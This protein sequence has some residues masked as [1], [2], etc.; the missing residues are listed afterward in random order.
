MSK[1][2][3][4]ISGEHSVA[5][6]KFRIAMNGGKFTKAQ[7]I[8]I[9][10]EDG[11]PTNKC[12]WSTFLKSGIIKKVGK[13]E[14]VFASDK[15]VCYTEL[16]KVYRQYRATMRGYRANNRKPKP[17]QQPEELEIPDEVGDLNEEELLVFEAF[18]IDFLKSLGYQVLKPVDIVYQPV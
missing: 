14:F 7:I 13:D 17:E 16:D 5:I 6:N 4:F 15:P 18:A 3:P 10:R 9:F 12:F 2:N 1:K 8:G 11:I